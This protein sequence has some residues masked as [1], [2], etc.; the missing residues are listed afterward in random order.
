MSFSSDD[1]LIS[2]QMPQTVNL[3]DMEEPENFT[4]KIED[5][6][7]DVAD[8]LNGKEGGLVSLQEKGTG[9]QYYNKDNEGALRNVYRKNF[10]VVSLNGGSI[11]GGET[12]QFAHEITNLCESAGI[13]ANCTTVDGLFFTASHP[14]VCLNRTSV[15]FI[16]PETEALVQCDVVANYLKN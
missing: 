7:K 13:L 3:P 15:I 14:D 6:F 8:S 2:N 10:D 5:L 9:A 12:I 11:G 1:A 4:N 16:N